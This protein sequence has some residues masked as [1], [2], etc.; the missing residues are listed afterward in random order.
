MTS[1]RWHHLSPEDFEGPSQPGYLKH[2]KAMQWS[3]FWGDEYAWTNR[4]P[5]AWSVIDSPYLHDT[6]VPQTAYIDGGPNADKYW[7]H[8]ASTWTSVLHLLIIGMGWTNI[9]AGLRS[10]RAEHYRLGHHPVLDLIATMC[11]KSDLQALEHF[12]H[13]WHN[14]ELMFR[15]SVLLDDT[16]QR[17]PEIRPEDERR[18]EAAIAD[19]LACASLLGRSLFSGGGTDPLHVVMHV[20]QWMERTERAREAKIQKISEGRYRV[21]ATSY[22]AGIGALARSDLTRL[23]DPD[24]HHT[25]AEAELVVEGLGSLGHYFG[26]TGK[27]WF[28]VSESYINI[29]AQFNSASWGALG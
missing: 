9:T 1:N 25:E 11:S 24:D 16:Y 29:A 18:D 5:V 23:D 2:E 6:V 10:W 13:P 15:I 8:R 12:L 26:V 19:N 3:D 20:Q 7:Y 14:N 21:V 28:R 4:L 22:A 17:R 27:R